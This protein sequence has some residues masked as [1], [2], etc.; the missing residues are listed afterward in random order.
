MSKGS[1]HFKGNASKKLEQ[2]AAISEISRASDQTHCSEQWSIG[3]ALWKNRW[4]LLEN[5]ITPIYLDPQTT[6]KEEEEAF[7]NHNVGLQEPMF[8]LEFRLGPGIFSTKWDKDTLEGFL[9][10][11]STV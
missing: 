8:K 10:V 5:G 1:F 11:T 7:T 9:D 4:V 2:G 3:G 6:Q